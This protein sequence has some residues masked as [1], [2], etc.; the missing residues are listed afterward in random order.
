M[1]LRAASIV[2]MGTDTVPRHGMLSLVDVRVECCNRC[3]GL[4]I[5]CLEGLSAKK[6]GAHGILFGPRGRVPGKRRQ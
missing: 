1:S 5:S 6:T 3:L 4:R 2:G